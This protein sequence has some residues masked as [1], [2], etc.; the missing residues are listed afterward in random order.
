MFSY[1]LIVEIY[2]LDYGKGAEFTRVF[3]HCHN[4]GHGTRTLEGVYLEEESTEP[5]CTLVCPWDEKG[6]NYAGII[7]FVLLHS[8][9]AS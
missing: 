6:F 9:R 7:I 2:A 1:T 4:C 3:D 8:A 5:R